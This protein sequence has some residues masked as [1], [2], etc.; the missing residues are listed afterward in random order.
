MIDKKVEFSNFFYKILDQ[1]KDLEIAFKEAH[2]MLK[3][4][5]FNPNYTVKIDEKFMLNEKQPNIA[6]WK[7]QISQNT[8]S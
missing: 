2:M 7:M 3:E 1:E 8:N 6:I 4:Y 5:A